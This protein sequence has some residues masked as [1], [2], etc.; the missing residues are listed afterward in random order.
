MSIWAG[1]AGAEERRT[2]NDTANKSEQ[3][4]PPHL[5]SSLFFLAGMSLLFYTCLPVLLSLSHTEALFKRATRLPT[6]VGQA[7]RQAI[8][9]FTFLPPS[10]SSDLPVTWTFEYTERACL[11]IWPI[12]RALV[13]RCELHSGSVS[14]RGQGVYWHTNA[15][16]ASRCSPLF[17]C[18]NS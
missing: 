3:P 12:Q 7:G 17:F 8:R 2:K 13:L 18:N 10:I 9:S 15:R 6:M 16:K 14:S 4:L 11:W 1:R 5:Q